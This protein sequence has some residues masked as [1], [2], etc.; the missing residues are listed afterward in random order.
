MSQGKSAGQSRHSDD[1]S[2]RPSTAGHWSQKKLLHVFVTAAMQPMS[3][4]EF[5][6]MWLE[7]VRER[8]RATTYKGYECLLRCHVPPGVRALALT[9]LRPLVLQ[10]VYGDLLA[11]IEGCRPLSGGSVLNLH[12][13]LT[14]AFGQAV[15]W[16]LLPSNPASGAQPPRPRRAQPVSVSPE[17]LERLIS[18]AT[19]TPLELPVAIAAATARKARELGTRVVTPDA[20]QTM[21]D[22]VQPALTPSKPAP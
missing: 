22:H 12:L 7:H 3:V 8:V 10:R 14:Q 13:V 5:L 2:S 18:A 1:W 20:F 11:G 4:S 15:R 16:E 21:L 6:E 17:L 9:D 19:G